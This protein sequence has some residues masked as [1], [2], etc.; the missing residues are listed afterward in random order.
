M[1]QTI[2]DQ[3]GWENA[4]SIPLSQGLINHTFDVHTAQGD[5]ILQNINTQ[6]FKDP[7]A[8]DHNIK[9]IGHFTIP[10]NQRNYSLIWCPI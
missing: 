7:F 9:T 5:F 6:V 3:Y 1:M 8:I 4:T 10:I 2:F